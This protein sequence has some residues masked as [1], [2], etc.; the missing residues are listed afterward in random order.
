M[1]YFQAIDPRQFSIFVNCTKIASLDR[2][3]YFPAARTLILTEIFDKILSP[4][5]SITTLIESMKS[6]VNSEIESVMK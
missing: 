1:S 5:I 6:P 2:L 3:G 4:D